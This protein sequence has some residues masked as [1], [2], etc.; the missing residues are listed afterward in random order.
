MVGRSH[1][2]PLRHIS[3]TGRANDWTPASGTPAAHP[4]SRFAAP[5]EQCPSFDPAWDDPAGVPISAIIVGGRLSKGMPLVFQSNS[6][7]HGVFMAAT[8]GSEATAAADKQ[9]AI[10][11]DP[12][13]MLPFCGYNMA[14]YWSHWLNIGRKLQAPPPVFRV[15]WFR[16][17]DNGK[18]MWPGFG[19]NMRVLQWIVDRARGR[20]SGVES[21]LGIVPT[22]DDLT[23]TGLDYSAEKY[24]SLMTIDPETLKSEAADLDRYFEQF[25]DTLPKEFVAERELLRGRAV[26]SAGLWQPPVKK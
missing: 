25:Y 17:D 14:R 15:N 13:A 9:A 2:Y 22:R 23:W 21:P 16:K 20:A 12:M 4:N 7:S 3:S 5:V 6:W 11:R 19:D 10:R 24:Q 26:R 1:R 8:M 18:F